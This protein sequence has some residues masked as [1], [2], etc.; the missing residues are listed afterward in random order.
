MLQ[1]V[2]LREQAQNATSFED[3]KCLVNHL[4]IAKYPPHD[5]YSDEHIKQT[6]EKANATEYVKQRS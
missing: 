1:S 6:L 3:L 4:I 5:R 2:S